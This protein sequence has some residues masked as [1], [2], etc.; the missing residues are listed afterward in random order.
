[1][2]EGSPPL[3]LERGEPVELPPALVIQR[4]K[5]DAHPLEMQERLVHWYRER[6]GQIEMPLFDNLP[7][8]PFRLS[9]EFP[10]TGRVVDTHPRLHSAIR[11]TRARIT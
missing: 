9:P 11:V 2:S 3:I 10:D 5:D 1:M 4:R 6:G 8:S 7:P